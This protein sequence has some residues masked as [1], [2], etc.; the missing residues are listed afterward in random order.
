MLGQCLDLGLKSVDLQGQLTT[1]LGDRN[2]EAGDEA[3]QTGETLA[4]A[5]EVADAVQRSRG[6]VPVAVE[7]VQ[8]PAQP[9]D[10]PG[11]F[12]D[13]GFAVVDEEPDVAVGSVQ[14][15]DGQVVL[16]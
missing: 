2:G 4:D 15:R 7:F 8:V 13:E 5:V 1:S 12:G 9:V 14:V 6:R 16:A 3:G 10:R 11:A